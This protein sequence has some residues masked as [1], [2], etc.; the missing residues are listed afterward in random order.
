MPEGFWFTPFGWWNEEA[1]AGAQLTQD[2]GEKKMLNDNIGGFQRTLEPGGASYSSESR[3]QVGLRQLG[4]ALS[5]IR[6]EVARLDAASK[7]RSD[8]HREHVA[9]LERQLKDLAAR[10]LPRSRA[11]VVTPA[12]GEHPVTTEA[13]GKALGTAPSPYSGPGSSLGAGGFYCRSCRR[14]YAVLRH[15]VSSILFRDRLRGGYWIKGI[16]GWSEITCDHCAAMAAQS[17]INSTFD[18]PL[19]HTDWGNAVE[20]AGG[21]R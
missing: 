14:P 16:K 12:V 6:E 4:E 17:G 20:P 7:E 15:F 21:F 10:R 2:N 3:L 11:A 9:K 18:E 13:S 8:D 19:R 1:N 5:T